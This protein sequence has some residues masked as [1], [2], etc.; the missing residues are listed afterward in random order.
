MTVMGLKNRY[1]EYEKYRGRTLANF[2]NLHLFFYDL[3]VSRLRRILKLLSGYFGK[4]DESESLDDSFYFSPLSQ[5][6][7]DSLNVQKVPIWLG[8]VKSRSSKTQICHF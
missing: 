5:S 7:L 8:A 3:A 2:Q 1:T 4:R 6:D